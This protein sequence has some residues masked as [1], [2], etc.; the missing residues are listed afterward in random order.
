MIRNTWACESINKQRQMYS[1]KFQSQTNFKDNHAS[2][3]FA[4][5]A[6]DYTPDIIYILCKHDIDTLTP[7]QY[8]IMRVG[9]RVKCKSR[10]KK[11]KK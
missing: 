1:E 6:S 10:K 2:S 11:K 7:R 9:E 8:A 4:K 3:H 5:S